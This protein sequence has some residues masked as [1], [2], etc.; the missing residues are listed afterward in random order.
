MSEVFLDIAVNA[1]IN[2][3]LTYSSDKHLPRGQP[4]TVP[5]GKRQ[6]TGLVIGETKNLST[7]KSKIKSIIATHPEWPLLSESTLKWLEWLS[8]Y[9]Q[10]PIG[11]VMDLAFP[12]LTKHTNRKQKAN[13][14]GQIIQKGKIH[15][16][17]D[18]QERC[19]QDINSHREFSTHLLFGV[20]GSGK[21]EVYL[22][23]FEKIIAEGKQG[24]FLVPEIS[25]TPQLVQ[26]F[27]SRF[28][29][30]IGVM[31][32]QLTERERTSQWWEAVNENKKILLG[33]RSA[34]FC[35]LP[36][37]GLVI[38]DE[39]H[40]P[41][42]KQDEKLK[43]H[44][45]DAAIMLAKFTNC[46]IV[47]G[48]ATPS[49]ESWNNATTGKYKLHTISSRIDEQTLPEIEIVDLKAV[50]KESPKLPFWLSPLLHQR[51]SETLAK[52]E[53]V[54]L[55]LNR[56][57]SAQLIL[58]SSCGESQKCPNCSV[59]L[60]LH[61]VRHMLCHYCDYHETLQIKCPTCHE[62]EL[63]K[64][65]LG[66]EKLEQDIANLFPEARIARA[67][68]DEIQNRSDLED[69]IKS[70][71]EHRID[72]LIGTQMIAKGL[73]FK[74]L[75]LVGLVLADIGFN[76][77]DF[78]SSER[79][80]QLILQVSG[81]SGRHKPGRVVVQTFNPEHLSIQYAMKSDYKGFA[82]LELGFRKT[83]G[84]PPFG[85]LA[86]LR[87]KSA[88]KAIAEKTSEDLSKQAK[89]IISR[90]PELKNLEILGPTEAPLSKL[91]GQYRYHL[92]IKGQT[93][94]QV[95]SFC[96]RI[97]NSLAQYSN[98]VKIQIDMDP[99]NLL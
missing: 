45:R 16:L 36:N 67:D 94:Q 85:R 6:C 10:Y 69:L 75:T 61:G 81:R 27:T 89:E 41:S 38:V 4:V 47:L 95:H 46:P 92:L 63:K 57:G 72:I 15:N 18:E 90:N 35:P 68:R 64:I 26:R 28:G 96:S 83:L 13:P 53:Q 3:V 82:N 11:Q 52:K 5:L 66:T 54:A 39:E 58:C 77:P 20:T 88:D 71:E 37:L 1:P 22:E 93:A 49:M 40:E 97:A 17:T 84:Y 33:A 59:T 51:I 44:A 8:N 70:I 60:T 32:S 98:K 86:A 42:F 79:S 34:L 25:L 74:G 12:P 78:R 23:L 65:G 7:D 48:S 55:F 24:L 29:N 14:L 30:L 31:H 19:F 50:E 2:S 73:D 91:K 9:Y 80:F 56:R 87:I 43:Y 21:T 62:G 76:M 99:L